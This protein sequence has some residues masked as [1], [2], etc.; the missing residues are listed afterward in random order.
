MRADRKTAKEIVQDEMKK[1]DDML[2]GM[3][4]GLR[5]ALKAVLKENMPNISEKELNDYKNSK[6]GNRTSTVANDA[7]AGLQAFKDLISQFPN[8]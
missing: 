2:G 3:K 5:G 6:N 8:Q 7:I 4:G 1:M